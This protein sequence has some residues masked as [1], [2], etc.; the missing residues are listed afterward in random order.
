MVV[1]FSMLLVQ[2]PNAAAWAG[3]PEIGNLHKNWTNDALQGLGLSPDVIESISSGA[4]WV[5]T[6][7]AT[8]V[9]PKATS[10]IE[11]ASNYLNEARELYS[12]GDPYWKDALGYAIHYMEDA[13]CPP[14]V[15]NWQQGYIPYFKAHTD[16]EYYTYEQYGS[17]FRSYVTGAPMQS[18]CCSEDLKYQLQQDQ[19]K[20]RKM[21]CMYWDNSDPPEY[22]INPTPFPGFNCANGA[23]P[24]SG[25]MDDWEMCDSDIGECLRMAT[26]ILRG[27]TIY[28]LS[29]TSAIDQGLCWLLNHQ[30]ADGSWSY[31]YPGGG[32]IPSVG[33]TSLATTAFLNYGIDEADPT[34]MKGLTFILSNLKAD[35]SITNWYG[36]YDTSM[37][38]LAL[39]STNNQQAYGSTVQNAVNYLIQAQNDEG[40]G[41]TPSDWFYGGWGYEEGQTF[42]SDMS[43]TQFVALALH[44]ADEKGWV[45]VSSQVWDKALV[46]VSKCQNLMQTNPTYA[47]FDDGGFVYNPTMNPWVAY[48]M[49]SYGSMTAAG[50]WSL[51]C[52]GLGNGDIRVQKALEWFGNNYYVDQDYPIGNAWLY[53]YLYSFAKAMTLSGTDQIAG[54]DWYQD[55]SSF[56]ASQQREDGAWVNS[57][58]GEYAGMEKEVMATAQAILALECKMTPAIQRSV[59]FAI[60][61]PADLHVYDP[62]GRHVGVN[63]QTGSI[64]LQ[65]PGAT[66]SGPGTEPQTI[67]ILDPGSGTYRVEIVGTG[68]GAWTLTIQGFI[69]E[70]LVYT[71]SYTGSITPGQTYESTATLSSIAGAL[72]ID[73]SPPQDTTPPPAP[74]LVSPGGGTMT[75]DNT[76]D[77]DWSDVSDPSTPVE[78]QVQVDNNN[79]FSSPEYDSGWIA[80]SN[81]ATSALDYDTY[82]WRARAKDSVNNES[83][84]SVVWQFQITNWV[85]LPLLPN[86][87]DNKPGRTMPIKFSIRVDASIDPAQPFVNLKDLTIKILDNSNIL[88][89]STFGSRST[90]YRIDTVGQKYVVNFQTLKTVMEYTVRVYRGEFLLGSFTF[91]TVK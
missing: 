86:S 81:A 62:D 58:S 38:V 88:Q 41:A 90:D 17:T 7:E 83:D 12:I 61:S 10:S 47:V 65:I 25:A 52:S 2:A 78:Y 49:Q 55:L 33:M 64:D 40:E 26:S 35:G 82:Y 42:W 59:T 76:V 30:N 1:C 63:Y 53:Y 71:K 18:V 79:D 23:S 85:V 51:T 91:N 56:L 74:T 5:D 66:Y 9:L 4:G 21:P 84:W 8:G 39:L 57:W 15:L 60:A 24:H 68:T 34:V 14:H 16:F 73:T 70:Q 22:M 54:H 28:V 45:S 13:V 11:A 69:D 36:L 50:L 43:N 31:A 89:T 72:T 19:E 77:L 37:A 44:E 20:V 3:T 46:F 29:G 87:G 27:A 67:T 75:T 6:Y 80:V 48:E 32:D